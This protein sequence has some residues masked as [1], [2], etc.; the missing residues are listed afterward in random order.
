LKLLDKGLPLCLIA[1]DILFKPFPGNGAILVSDSDKLMNSLV[2]LLPV[3]WS[4][5]DAS[6]IKDVLDMS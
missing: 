3:P 6:L 4:Q 1:F 5:G 2:N